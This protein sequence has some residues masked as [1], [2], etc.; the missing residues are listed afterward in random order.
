MS[1]FNAKSLC[2]LGRQPELGLAELESLY[3]PER[4]RPLLN[5]ALLD[6]PAAEIQFNRLGGIIKTAKILAVIPSS[7]WDSLFKYLLNRIPEHLK[8]LPEG[9]FT[10]GLSVYGL[11]VNA[12]V[13]SRSLITIKKQIKDSGRPVRIVPNKTPALSSAQVLHNKLT[14]RGNW[15]LILIPDGLNTIL[16]QTLF[17]QDIDAYAARDQ[18]RPS[19]DAKVGMLPPK[20]AQI[21]INL[22]V[23]QIE[24]QLA[25]S[26]PPRTVRVLDPF[27]GSGVILQ[28]ALMMG[29]DVVG[30]DIDP[31]M[32]EYSK[33]NIQWLVKQQPK[34][35]GHA[36]IE[37][38]DATSYQWP[39][40]STIASEIYL[41]P[42]M[43]QPPSADNLK[44]IVQ[45][46]N[47]VAEKFLLNL[48]PQL[49]TG[50]RICLALPVW[51]HKDKLV[52][53]P[54]IAKLTDMGYNIVKLRHVNSGALVYFREDQIVAR[55][56]IVLEK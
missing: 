34:I 47:T 36:S 14:F 46:V 31:R 23:G 26:N 28:E 3:G 18:A 30:T 15:E 35:S 50:Q 25:K 16:A 11:K 6:I 20:L 51:R 42:P 4:V 49:R 7:D 2:I 27:C 19:R 10:L 44:K 21:V 24:K 45:N 32:V 52:H 40:F 17:V 12:N 33:T 22:A 37:V 39:R 55:Q 43:A 48:E 53:L 5:A 56:L 8:H 29:Y 54:V 13:I 9:K 38:A 1:Q 41:G